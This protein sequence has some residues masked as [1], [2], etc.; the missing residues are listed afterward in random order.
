MLVKKNLSVKPTAISKSG[1]G[2]LGIRCESD[3]GIGA[4]QK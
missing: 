3:V 1:E 4:D 2:S